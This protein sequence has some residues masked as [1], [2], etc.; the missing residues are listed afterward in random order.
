MNAIP[1]NKTEVRRD[2]VEPPQPEGACSTDRRA[3]QCPADASLIFPR[4]HPFGGQCPR[5]ELN[6]VYD[7]RR[8]AC[9]SPTLRGQ[10]DQE[11]NTIPC[12]GIEPG[13]TA[14]KTVVR[15]PHSQGK[16]AAIVSHP[17]DVLARIRIFAPDR[18]R[19]CTLCLRRATLYPVELPGF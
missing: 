9:E 5:Q 18:D 14:S 4:D 17:L 11:N 16:T 7:L 3:L 15:P 2:G 13:P 6:L 10:T 19:T 12:P 1:F 8:V